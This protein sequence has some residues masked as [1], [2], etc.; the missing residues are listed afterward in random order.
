MSGQPSTD[1]AQST[2]APYPTK[3]N[4]DLPR[5]EVTFGARS[6]S[7]KVRQNNEDHY[8]V[9]RLAK[10]MQV[11]MS[12]VPDSGSRLF[13]EEVG[14]LLVVADGM[15]GAA[16]GEHASALAITTVEDFALNTLKWFFHLGGG[17]EHAL[18]AEL[19]SGI[20]LADRAVINRARSDP[21][22]HGMG[23]TLTMAYSVN[24]EL[25]I[26]HAGDTRAYLFHEGALQQITNDHT[27][28]Q[29]L[30][31]HGAL[32][33]EAAK[34]HK[35]RNVVTNVVGGPSAG[36]HAEVHKV[37]VADGDVL[38]LCSD[39]LSEPTTDDAIAAILADE[40]A[41]QAAA[42][43]LVDLALKGGGPDNVTAIVARYH[44]A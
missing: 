4:S 8:L 19:R 14:Y 24:T 15:G 9:T 6:H 1:N 33:P 12:S 18:L 40:A 2:T 44:V 29:M 34:H 21:R 7:G 13:S 25:Y 23:T 22:L 31:N 32:T 26:V 43:A 17:E 28:V 35:R 37:H 42:D 36:V 11:C 27:L 41:P 38:L 16:A 3:A 39:G 30:V 20:E 10:I 5:V